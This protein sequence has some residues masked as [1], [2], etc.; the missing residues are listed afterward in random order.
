MPTISL[1]LSDEQ[2]E[3]LKRWAR[4]DSRSIQREIIFRLFSPYVV[5]DRS[6][7]ERAKLA[8]P[9]RTVDQPLVGDAQQPRSVD[10][11]LVDEDHFRPD[12]KSG[13]KKRAR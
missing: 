1:R 8:Y 5:H 11:P 12:F 10:Q 6:D 3:E 9:L 7:D 2:H 4:E 13:G